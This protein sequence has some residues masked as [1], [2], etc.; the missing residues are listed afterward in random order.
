[1]ITK[2]SKTSKKVVF[3]IKTRLILAF[4]AILIVPCI[5]IGWISYQTAATQVTNQIMANAT[6]SVQAANNEITDLIASAISDMDYLASRVHSDMIDGTNSPQIRSVLDPYKSVHSQFLSVYFGTEA[7]LM[8]SSPQIE[9]KGYDPRTSAWYMKAMANKGVAMFNDPSI[10]ASTGQVVVVPFKA[11]SDGSGVVGGNLDLTKLAETISRIKIGTNGYVTILDKDQKYL[12]HPSIAPGTLS[13][14]DF[15]PYFYKSDTGIQDYEFKGKNK[16]AVF[17]TNKLT[18]WK[19]IGG[20]ELA[21]IETATRGILYTTVAVIAAAIILGALLIYGIIRSITVPLRQL[22]SA[23]EKIADGDL[24][25]EIAIRSMDELGQLSVSVNH[26]IHKWRDLIGGVLST[27]ENVAAASEQISATTEEVAKGSMVQ[28]EA[29]QT[30]HEQFSELSAAINAVAESAEEASKLAAQ[31]TLIA[32]K[33]GETVQ[34]SVDSMNQVS[35]QMERLEEDSV[36]IG[37]IID[38]IYSIAEQTNLLA[39]NAAIEA[40]R[41]GDQGRGFAVV[42]NEVRK[43]AERSREATTQITAIIKGMQAN[44]HK[45]VVVVSGGVNQSQQ[46]GQAFAEIIAMINNT[47]RKVNE[48]AAA[49][50][51]QAAQA[52]EV[53]KAI[54][55]IAS[56][57][58]EAAAAAEE[59]AATSQSLAL[60]AEGLNESVSIF[61]IK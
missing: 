20:I 40:A 36:K 32:L 30:M 54:E 37:E 27:S 18:G 44:T 10:S 5:S 46:T 21:E 29:G 61:K 2:K 15:V 6:E 55:S 42:A 31:T 41:A 38:V 34:H 9:V 49:S 56:V 53:M 48:I 22:M 23:T 47:E 13:S 57:S 4:L 24:T 17:A 11:A 19:I 8:I 52:D 25:E 26:M 16:K 7:G 58:E 3:T 39:L 51:E 60:L 1:M 35:S 43:L 45:S 14:E 50:E 59:T 33:G 12:V 28:A